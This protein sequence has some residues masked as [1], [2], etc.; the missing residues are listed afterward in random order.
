MGPFLDEIL[1][2]LKVGLQPNCEMNCVFAEMHTTCGLSNGSLTNDH[3]TKTT[4]Q[5]S[6]IKEK[7]TRAKKTRAKKTVICVLCR[8]IC[9]RMDSNVVYIISISKPSKL[10]YTNVNI[11]SV[12][13]SAAYYCRTR[14][15]YDWFL[16]W[17]L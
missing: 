7:K 3:R 8:P 17:Y 2:S 4:L 13:D 15:N 14:A 16:F 5:K 9:I 11:L 6:R 12:F 10:D 1:E